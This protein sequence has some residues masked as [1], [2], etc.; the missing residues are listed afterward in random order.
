MRIGHQA[1][2]RLLS[3]CLLGASALAGLATTSTH[4]ILP[5]RAG[6]TVRRAGKVSSTSGNSTYGL[7]GAGASRPQEQTLL[8]EVGRLA[9]PV[10][11]DHAAAWKA[12]LAVQPASPE[13]A[14]WN[15]IWLGEW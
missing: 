11:P 14:A 13:Q 12:A 15:H 9:A 10:P 2:V 5:L 4:P 6:P 3:G 1:F 7:L 8:D